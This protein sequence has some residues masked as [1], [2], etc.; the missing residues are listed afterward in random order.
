MLGAM[1]TFNCLN[2][3]DVKKAEA[4]STAEAFDFFTQVVLSQHLDQKRGHSSR[5][6]GT[7]GARTVR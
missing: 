4:M 5:W 7:S 3:D 6:I 1:L 2:G